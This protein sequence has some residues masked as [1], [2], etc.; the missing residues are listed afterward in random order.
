MV[1]EVNIMKPEE[2]IE[3]YLRTRAEQLGFLCYKF[4]SPGNNGVPDRILI[5]HGTTFFV[6]TKAPGEKPRK[7]QEKVIER[8]NNHGGIAMVIDN[9]DDI[10]TILEAIIQQKNTRVKKS[11]KK[12]SSK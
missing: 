12:V 4:T 5:G 9:K 1:F 8:I 7:L 10:D 11:R 2:T 3:Q 6:E